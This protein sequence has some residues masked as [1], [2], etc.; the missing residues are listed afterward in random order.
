MYHRAEWNDKFWHEFLNTMA[1]FGTLLLCQ[2]L[3]YQI[4][5]VPNTPPPRPPVP[6]SHNQRLTSGCSKSQLE[7]MRVT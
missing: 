4:S 3:P 6:L 7:D 2:I 5:P 1:K